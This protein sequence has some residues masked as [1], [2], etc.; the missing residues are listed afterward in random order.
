[1]I[2]HHE[3]VG[4]ND[5]PCIVLSTS[6][7]ARMQMW[8]PQMQVLTQHFRVLRYDMRGHGGSPS[9]VGPYSIADLGNDVLQLLDHHDIPSTHFCGI[10]LGGVIG[11]WLGVHAPDRIEKLV[12]CNTAAK[13]GTEEGWQKRITEVRA[14][15][16]ASIAD[17]VI[18]RWFTEPFAA[19]H[20]EVVASIRE[21]M[22]ACNPEGYV[23]CCEALR[24]C[25]LRNEIA[26]ITAPS[27]VIAGDHDVVCTPADAQFL[28]SQIPTSQQRVLPAAHL[29]NV[30]AAENFNQSLLSFLQ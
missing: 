27:L 19:S 15:G 26:S 17:T 22:P 10:S 12:L 18:S 1:M 21:G 6:L 14:N 25:D 30:E 5:A 7:G 3:L 8:Q 2:L 4:E 28:Q 24:T 11:Q 23:A 13:V 16:M 29:S 20:V 9:P